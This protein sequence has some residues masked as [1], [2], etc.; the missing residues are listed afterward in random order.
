MNDEPMTFTH[1]AYAPLPSS[2]M[3]QKLSFSWISAM[4]KDTY[5]ILNLAEG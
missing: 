3:F 1:K 5:S 2:P 4:I